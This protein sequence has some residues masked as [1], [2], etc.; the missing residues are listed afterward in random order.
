MTD[1]AQ[2]PVSAAARFS[3]DTFD[4]FL[5]RSIWRPARMIGA[6]LESPEFVELNEQLDPDFFQRAFFEIYWIRG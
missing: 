3:S 6:F 2:L 5:A 1:R 4:R